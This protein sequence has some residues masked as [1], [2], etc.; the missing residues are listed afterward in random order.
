MN[1]R[2]DLALDINKKYNIKKEAFNKSIKIL[3]SWIK[4]QDIVQINRWV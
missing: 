3:E 1:F 2:T 4:I